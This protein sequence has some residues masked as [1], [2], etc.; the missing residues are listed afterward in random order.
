MAQTVVGTLVAL[1]LAWSLHSVW[2]VVGGT[3][4][5]AATAVI[6]SYVLVPIR[7]SLAWDRPAANGIYEL[8]HQ[9]FLN[10][11]IMA[12][13]LN[14]PQLL[15]LRLVDAAEL[16]FY[17]VAW[18][19]AVVAEGL[20]TR[21]C[22]VYFSML[23]R[24]DEG[25]RRLAWHNSVSRRV[26]RLA[27]PLLAVGVLLAPLTIHILY[28][29]RY[30]AAGVLFAVLL[31]RLMV[32]LLGQVQFQLLM[33]TAQVRL[34]TRAYVVAAVVQ[35]VCL[36]AF[37]QLWGVLGIAMAVYAATVVLTAVQTGL[38]RRVT[39]TSE[40]APFVRTVLWASSALALVL[41]FS[42]F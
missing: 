14:L 23:S 27:M 17:M 32:R 18:N 31:A 28:D 30:A 29:R 41:T 6:V 33:V 13:V 42:G 3:M 22:D 12:L 35:V 38:L 20:F 8:G 19:L 16:G 36:F 7:P 37:V 2:A 9:V 11:L 25:P 24:L 15:G 10:T 5:G 21:A 40:W 4:A 34:A 26:A 39:G 1:G